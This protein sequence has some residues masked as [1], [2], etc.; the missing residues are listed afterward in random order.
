MQNVNQF[1]P[2]MMP[3][4]LPKKPK[5]HKPMHFGSLGLGGKPKPKSVMMGY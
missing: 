3:K 1:Q 2:A 4:M 5:K